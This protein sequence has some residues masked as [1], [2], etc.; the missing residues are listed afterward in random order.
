MTSLFIFHDSGRMV[1]LFPNKVEYLVPYSSCSALCVWIQFCCRLP[2][3]AVCQIHQVSKSL[4]K[5]QLIRSILSEVQFRSYS[6]QLQSD[7]HTH[8]RKKQQKPT[9]TTTISTLHTTQS[10]N[11]GTS[12]RFC[13]VQYWSPPI[14][15]FSQLLSWSDRCFLC[16]RPPPYLPLWP[17]SKQQHGDSITIYASTKR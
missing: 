5:N 2:R 1:V 13:Q 3:P 7:T 11:A 14:L 16:R 17:K 9:T 12:N 8:C 6:W 10:L 15:F 4:R